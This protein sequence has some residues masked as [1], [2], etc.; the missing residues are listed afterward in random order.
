MATDPILGYRIREGVRRAVAARNA[1]WSSIAAII[2]EVGC[3]DA[4]VRLPLSDLHSP[5]AIVVR[6]YRYVRSVEYPTATLGSQPPPIVVSPIRSL[7]VLASLTPIALV[8]LV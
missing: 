3:A 5:K 7:Q 1:G 6:D 2:V 8:K 4:A